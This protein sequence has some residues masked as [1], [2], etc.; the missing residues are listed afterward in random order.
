M[1]I[2]LYVSAA[3]GGGGGGT[4]HTVAVNA[5]LGLEDNPERTAQY[6]RLTID[7]AP[8]V[9]VYQRL[10]GYRRL[11]T[12]QLSLIDAYQRITSYYR[13]QTDQLPVTDY[14]QFAVFGYRAVL[15][16]DQLG[17]APLLRL[18]TQ[19]GRLC[20]DE[21]LCHDEI[22]RSVVFAIAIIDTCGVYDELEALLGQLTAG[23]ARSRITNQSGTGRLVRNTLTNAGG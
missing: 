12:D 1:I 16:S 6:N 11:Y 17:L 22:S 10:A 15:L 4:N 7:S 5:S 20:T 8:L 13:K 9:D 2:P 21:V 23:I 14:S 18:S 19:Y 3:G